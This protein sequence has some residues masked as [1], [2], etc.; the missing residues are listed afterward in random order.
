MLSACSPPGMEAKHSN[1][2]RGFVH[3]ARRSRH[4]PAVASMSTCLRNEGEERVRAAYGA[5]YER[6]VALKN[7]DDPT[8]FCSLNQNIRPTRRD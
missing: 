1:T 3:A 7:T 4:M 5:N 6:L 8:N 2:S